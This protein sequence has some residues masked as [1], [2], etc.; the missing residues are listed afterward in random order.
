M[1]DTSLTQRIPL[2]QAQAIAEEVYNALHPHCDRIQIAGSIRRQKASIGDVEVV[3]I[4][5]QVPSGLF[6]D[7]LEVEPA[8]VAAVNQWPAVKGQPTGKYTQRVLPSGMKLDL[9]MAAPDNW[10]LILAI[11]TGSAGFSEHVLARR[12]KQMGYTSVGGQLH[13]RDGHVVTLRE[14]TDVFRVLGLPWV[15]PWA[16]EV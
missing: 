1:S 11:R 6:G 10:G 12:W 14:E 9:F 3:C 4:P 2:A 5:R 8:F 7:E 13:H 16:R 15:D